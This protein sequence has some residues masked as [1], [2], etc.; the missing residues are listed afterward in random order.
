M[1]FCTCKLKLF[2]GTYADFKGAK[3]RKRKFLRPI[4]MEILF[5]HLGDLGMSAKKIGTE[6]GRNVKYEA[7]CCSPKYLF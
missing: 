6:S 2:F 4:V 5:L 7:G 1:F 3:S